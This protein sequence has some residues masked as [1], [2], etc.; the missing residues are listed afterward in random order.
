MGDK[1]ALATADATVKFA[2]ALFHQ[3]LLDSSALFEI[4]W[5]LAKGMCTI[6]Q[7]FA[8]RLMIQA[9]DGKFEAAH[10]EEFGKFMKRLDQKHLDVF[11]STLASGP[12]VRE[13]VERQYRVRLHRACW[14]GTD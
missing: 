10:Q 4:L 13:D 11:H 12:V 14:T 1:F 7:L 8:V 9:L 3:S 2:A 6:E 5:S